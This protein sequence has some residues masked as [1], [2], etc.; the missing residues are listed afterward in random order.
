MNF[1][2]GAEGFEPS[3]A[4][5]SDLQS[6]RKNE[7]STRFCGVLQMCRALCGALERIVL[8]LRLGNPYPMYGCQPQFIFQ[9]GQ[10]GNPMASSDQMVWHIARIQAHEVGTPTREFLRPVRIRPTRHAR[11]L[12]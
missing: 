10:H 11:S 4:E 9:H 7:I 12:P 3:K 6:R 2:M 5:P 1:E 8:P